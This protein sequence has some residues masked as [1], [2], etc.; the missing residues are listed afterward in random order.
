LKRCGMSET[1][2]GSSVWNKG[3][4]ITRPLS[5]ARTP[6]CRPDIDPTAV[7]PRTRACEEQVGQQRINTAEKHI[8]RENLRLSRLHL[9]IRFIA[10]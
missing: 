4:L 2:L 9:G 3:F 8:L 10:A 7:T 5:L 1:G 6:N